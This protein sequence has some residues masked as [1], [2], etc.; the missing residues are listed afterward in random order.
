LIGGLRRRD[1]EAAAAQAENYETKPNNPLLSRILSEEH[2][3]DREV[4]YRKTVPTPPA[5]RQGS[6]FEAGSFSEV[7]QA[8]AG[9]LG[10][11]SHTSFA[12]TNPLNR[13]KSRNFMADARRD[14]VL[15][16]A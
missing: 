7:A 2:D 4:S 6:I 13:G 1:E 8:S 5:I 3:Q 11:A 9:V 14:V 15:E 12:K 10:D 16:R